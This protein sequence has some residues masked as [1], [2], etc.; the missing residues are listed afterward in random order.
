MGTEPAVPRRAIWP[1]P[2]LVAVAV[3]LRVGAVAVAG[4]G[5]TA[6]PAAGSDGAEY[7]ILSWNLVQGRGYVGISP[8]VLGPDGKELEHT[9]AY[10]PPVAPLFYAAVYAAVGHNFAAAHVA[11][12][13]LGGLTVLLVWAVGRRLGGPAAGWLAGA[14]YAVYPQA[15]YYSLTMLSETQGA[16]LVVLFVWLLL[17]L[18]GPR[19]G[20]WAAAA[21]AALGLLLLCKPGYV[22]LFPLLP[23]WALAVCRRDRRL[24]LRAALVPAVAGLLFAPWVVRNQM[25]M[26]VLSP[27][28]GGGSL[29][30][31]ANNRL[32]VA[33]P[34]FHGYAVWD[35]SLPEYAPSI[36]EPNDEVR[37]DAVARGHAVAWLKANPD[38]WFYL[39]RGKVWRLFTPGYFGAKWAQVA[40]VNYLA[41]FPVLVLFLL[42]VGP[43]TARWVRRRDPALMIPALV[44]A[45]TGIAVVFHGQHRY[46]F[47]IDSLLIVVAAVGAVWGWRAV[48]GWRRGYGP[49]PV[50]RASARNVLLLA[51]AVAAAG[52]YWLAARADD[53]RVHAW[54]AGLDRER[55]AAI[56]DAVG[57]YRA[58]TGRLPARVE[59]LVPD[60]LPNAEAVHAPTHSLAYHE[61]QLL[62]AAGPAALEKVTSYAVQPDPAADRGFR[63][64]QVRGTPP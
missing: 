58:A 36:R 54:R 62:G 51:V 14:A 56:E 2:L 64:V 10:R 15:L 26:G 53:A 63:V 37:R 48:A 33:D 22:F 55:V 41:Y 32:V 3:A 59:E 49:L 23:V 24:W 8:D 60:Y 43:V 35:T 20:R 42:A 28:T 12:A 6:P 11:D 5:L 34:L 7:D 47:P 17:P 30:L 1:L 4:G 38:K 45:T 25:T 31:Q 27:G 57:R 50:P 13:L 44:L 19:G 46:R 21:G 18:R 40:V 29:L 9:T 16:F 39:A 61:Y 52:G